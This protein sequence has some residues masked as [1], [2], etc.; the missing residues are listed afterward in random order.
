MI[1]IDATYKLT[2]QGFPLIVAGTV[3]KCKQF[4]PIAVCLSKKEDAH[5]YAFVFNAIRQAYKHHNPL[6]EYKP[7]QLLADAAQA[8]TNG[9]MSAFTD[10][11]KRIVCWAHVIRNIDDKLKTISDK[12][13]RFNI[14]TDICNL[15]LCPRADM[16]NTASKLL[17]NKWKNHGD[18]E[19]VL[20]FLTY[21]QNQWLGDRNVGWYEG[22]SLGVPSTNNALESNNGVIKNDGKE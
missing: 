5:D 9:F 11:D 4:H 13:I 14:R 8:I 6:Y 21:F 3:D 22:F 10:I 16:F 12:K 20:D 18:D 7:T 1:A 19:K 2:W 15:Q 17:I